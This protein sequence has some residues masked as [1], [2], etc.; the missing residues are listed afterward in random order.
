M[1]RLDEA[2]AR[3]AATEVPA[4]RGR[5][6]ALE[7]AALGMRVLGR[8]VDHG[9]ELLER[10]G[11]DTE[12]VRQ[13]RDA[14]RLLGRRPFFESQVHGAARTLSDAVA[15]V[16]T[17]NASLL[18]DAAGRFDAEIAPAREVLAGISGTPTREQR[19]ALAAALAYDAQFDD[20]ANARL[21]DRLLASVTMDNRVSL[22]RDMVAHLADDLQ[23]DELRLLGR[24]I[25]GRQHG[26]TGGI[27][28]FGA[29]PPYSSR[30]DEAISGAAT[31]NPRRVRNLDRFFAL[32]VVTRMAEHER[33]DMTA[34]LFSKDVSE[35]DPREWNMLEA[36]T[37]KEIVGWDNE[38]VTYIEGHEDLSR[39][40]AFRTMQGLPPS[41]SMYAYFDANALKGVA[42]SERARIVEARFN[43]ALEEAAGGSPSKASQTLLTAAWPA[44]VDRVSRMPIERQSAIAMTLLG[45]PSGPSGDLQAVRAAIH[46]IDQDLASMKVPT[47]FEDLYAQT[48]VL[49]DRNVARMEGR[50]DPTV[51][52]GYSIHPRLRRGRAG[53]RQRRAPARGARHGGRGRSCAR[54]V[55]AS[56][57]D[58]D[59]VGDR[60]VA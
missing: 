17:R 37:N 38:I 9:V 57:R 3:I 18:A 46:A 19:T 11:I 44:A 16:R 45:L 4:L 51:N 43:A 30:L 53:P 36:L 58:P 21:H 60:L 56:C 34:A 25:Q 6:Y 41:E 50:R 49:I 22:L 10:A 28:A 1:T 26:R 2:A 7:G 52:R 5:A 8:E 13:V 35:L 27:F 42:T 33:L 55:D 12:S 40:I 29:D 24:L 20:F 15:G 54:S 14:A 32:D 48:K 39:H 23:P 47:Q 31:G 59:L